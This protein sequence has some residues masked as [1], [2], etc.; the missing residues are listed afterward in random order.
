MDTAGALLGLLV[1]VLLAFAGGEALSR[2][3]RGL[4]APAAAGFAAFA[5]VLASAVPE[6]SFAMRAAALDLPG[7]AIGAVAGS[8]I[9]NAFIA[10]LVAASG[11]HDQARGGRTFSV[12]SAVAAGALLFVAF[13][14]V[15]TRGEGA[16]M[17]AGALL[18]AVRAARLDLRA[19]EQPPR[20]PLAAS[21]LLLAV[22]AALCAGGA[23]LALDQTADLARGRADGDLLIGLTALGAGAALPEIAAALIAARKGCGAR[24]LVN[25]AA[26]TALTLFGAVGA[27]ALVRPLTVA[28]PFHGAP[29]AALAAAAVVLMAV[30]TSKRRLASGFALVGALV[31]ATGVGAYVWSMA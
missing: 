2:G 12:A 28:D 26:G 9:A 1:G 14:G 7:A 3:A 31:W 27:A 29:A 15:V 4:I 21:I 19:D 16:L 20:P 6:Y 30:A 8:F 11:A 13:D 22:G 18:V 17:L 24:A 10:S 25:V 5:A 23:W